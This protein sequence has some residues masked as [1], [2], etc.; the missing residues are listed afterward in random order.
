M[1]GKEVKGRVKG[2]KGEGKGRED[3]WKPR[4]GRREG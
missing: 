3:E 2:G 1:K 4:E